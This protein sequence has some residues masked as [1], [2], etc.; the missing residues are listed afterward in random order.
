MSV[1]LELLLYIFSFGA[2]N[3]KEQII[4]CSVD[5]YLKNFCTRLLEEVKARISLQHI[6]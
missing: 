6:A 1:I 4:I 5:V 3:E 2:F